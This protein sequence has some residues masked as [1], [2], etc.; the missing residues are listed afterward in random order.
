MFPDQSLSAIPVEVGSGV[1]NAGQ[2]N[3]GYVMCGE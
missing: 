2:V 1:T 3:S